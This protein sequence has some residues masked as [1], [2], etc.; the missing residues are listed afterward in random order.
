MSSWTLP[1][2][3]RSSY[4]IT[5]KYIQIYKAALA[6]SRPS[7]DGYDVVYRIQS[8]VFVLQVVHVLHVRYVLSNVRGVL[9]L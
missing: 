7:A 5:L 6:V 9:L 1:E 8:A 2:I 3:L 4:C